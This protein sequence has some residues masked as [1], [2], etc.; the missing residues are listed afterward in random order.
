[1]L[2]ESVFG[3]WVLGAANLERC[4]WRSTDGFVDLP[5]CC[6]ELFCLAESELLCLAESGAL[7]LFNTFMIGA[8]T[9]LQQHPMLP[10][11]QE[12]GRLWFVGLP[13]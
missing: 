6:L 10:W 7:N 11:I 9:V 13:W 4:W 3:P 1:V 2:L 5:S 8:L 12:E